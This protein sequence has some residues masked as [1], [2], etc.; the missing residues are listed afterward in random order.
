MLEG[1]EGRYSRTEETLSHM[2]ERGAVKMSRDLLSGYKGNKESGVFYRL[3]SR[4]M[5]DGTKVYAILRDYGDRLDG[6]PYNDVSL[7]CV[8]DG[9]V[10]AY[11]KAYNLFQLFI[12]V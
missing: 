3:V 4:P 5:F 9:T 8:D 7:V 6:T 2:E 1:T 12:N 11:R 10:E